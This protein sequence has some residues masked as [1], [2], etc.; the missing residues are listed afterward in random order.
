MKPISAPP[1]VLLSIS[2]LLAAA[3]LGEGCDQ[4]ARVP[5]STS[6]P[7]ADRFNQLK[8]GMSP[9]EVVQLIG[10]P[11]HKENA[12]SA[13]LHGVNQPGGIREHAAA[14]IRNRRVGRGRS[15]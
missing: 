1:V 15:D 3:F 7:T 5:D 9:A 8:P 10:E 4:S 6:G 13:A 14:G 11:T 12:A 2:F